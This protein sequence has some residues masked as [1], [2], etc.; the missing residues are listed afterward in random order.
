MSRTVTTQVPPG[1][2]SLGTG[3]AGSLSLHPRPGWHDNS[4]R[5]YYTREGRKELLHPIP[6][7][8]AGSGKRGKDIPVACFANFL[9]KG[10]IDERLSVSSIF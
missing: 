7:P 9:F 5:T 4:K 8:K 6:A 10:R 3:H 2:G 1:Y